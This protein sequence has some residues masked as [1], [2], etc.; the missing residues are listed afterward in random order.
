MMPQ[1]VLEA[2]GVSFTYPGR[3]PFHALVDV[4]LALRERE[5]LALVGE[6]GSGKSTLTR[7]LLGLARPTGGHVTCFGEEISAIS[8]R[9]RA[10]LLQPVFQDPFGSLNPHQTLAEIVAGPLLAQ[11]WGRGR[12]LSKATETFD[13]VGLPRDFAA[14][15]PQALSGGQRQRVAIARALV[16][17]PRILICDE[18]TSA[19]DVSV[20]AQILRLLS[21]LK[22]ERGLSMLLVTHNIGVVAHMADHVAVM[23]GG[24]I[25]EAAPTADALLTP[26]HPYTQRLLASVL[27]HAA[28]PVTV[29]ATA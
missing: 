17:D 4:S 22:A 8:R 7:L 26:Q 20:Q 11:G 14:R 5:T 3:P 19:L 23:Q 1:V 10:A 21:R 12:A 15:R 24:R 18:P 27:G 25:V 6:S 9:A 28:P 2:R 16:A 13:D 29:S